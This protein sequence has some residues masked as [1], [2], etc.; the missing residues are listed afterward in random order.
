MTT[1]KTLLEDHL[2]HLQK[3]VD[4]LCREFDLFRGYC[5]QQ[6]TI[7]HERLDAIEATM[8][9][10]AEPRTIKVDID[11]LKSDLTIL[12][13]LVTKIALKVGVEGIA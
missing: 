11:N 2:T 5:N 10:K 6:F 8:A 4:M 1:T 3:Q 9:T 7:I 12:T 13:N